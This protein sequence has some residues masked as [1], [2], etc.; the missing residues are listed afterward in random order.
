MASRCYGNTGSEQPFNG[1][2]RVIVQ[3][4]IYSSNQEVF[5]VTWHM[6]WAVKVALLYRFHSVARRRHLVG[7]LANKGSAGQPIN[8]A[9]NAGLACERGLTGK[10]LSRLG[11]AYSDR[12][13]FTSDSE[14]RYRLTGLV[15]TGRYCDCGAVSSLP[16]PPHTSILRVHS[17]TLPAITRHLQIAQFLSTS[18]GDQWAGNESQ[19]HTVGT[20]HSHCK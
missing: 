5:V 14:R 4:R 12:P 7:N 9:I 17:H 1:P 20:F 13:H 10:V 16:R 2:Y 11:G 3:R 19:Q 6:T 18:S 15:T 8:A